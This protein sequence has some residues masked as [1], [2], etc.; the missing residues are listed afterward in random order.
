MDIALIAMIVV[1][2]AAV[3]ATLVALVR[4]RAPRVATDPARLTHLRDRIASQEE[5]RHR[6]EL[7]ARVA[8][9]SDARDVSIAP[10]R[11]DPRDPTPERI[12]AGAF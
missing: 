2:G 11:R 10:Q 8:A 3:T 1:G 6:D 9:E 12:W 5:Q 7:V 4:Q